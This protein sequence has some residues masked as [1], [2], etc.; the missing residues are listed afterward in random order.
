MVKVAGQGKKIEETVTFANGVSLLAGHEMTAEQESLVRAVVSGEMT[1]E[2]A[3]AI[4]KAQV[5]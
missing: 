3:I 1:V 4:A 5:K 2:E